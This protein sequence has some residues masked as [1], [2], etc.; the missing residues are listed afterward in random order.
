MS[1]NVKF[2]IAN[3]WQTAGV[4]IIPEPVPPQVTMYSIS[5]L[6]TLAISNITTCEKYGRK[7]KLDEEEY[8]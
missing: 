1:E 6:L 2:P 8:R 5:C 3:G 4:D 7:I